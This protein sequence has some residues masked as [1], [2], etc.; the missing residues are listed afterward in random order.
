[1][2]KSNIAA[3]HLKLEDW[4]SAI[5]TATAALDALERLFPKKTE[6]GDMKEDEGAVV[7]LGGDDE[8]AEKELARLQVSD[9]R[10]T[11][12]QR[13]RSK[14]MMR[15]AKARAEEAGWGNLQGAEEGIAVIPHD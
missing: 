12:I 14:A 3:C 15:R 2:L 4:K 7:E 1:M 6:K 13:I 10:R 11:D 8:A 9:Q 5:E